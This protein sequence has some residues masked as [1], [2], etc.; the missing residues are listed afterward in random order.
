MRRRDAIAVEVTPPSSGITLAFDRFTTLQV[1]LDLTTPSMAAFEVGDDASWEAIAS[2]VQI[3]TLAA[4]FVNGRRKMTGKIRLHDIPVD[5]S[6]GVAIRFTVQTKMAEAAVAVADPSIVVKDVSLKSFILALYRPLGLTERD[7]IFDPATSRDLLTG[8]EGRWGKPPPN[9]EAMKEE[10]AVVNPPETIFAAADR[11]LRRFGLMHWDAPDGRIVVGRPD[12]EQIPI[13][14]FRMFRD[15]I[16][17]RANNVLRMGRSRDY[18]QVPTV[19]GIYGSGSKLGW[20]RA[21]VS[22]VVQDD[23]VLAAGLYHPVMIFADSIQ[24]EQMAKAVANREMS[25]R[26]RDKDTF[27]VQ[28]DGHSFWDGDESTAEFGIDTVAE[29]LADVI[30]GPQGAYLVHRVTFDLD[31]S[32]GGTTTLEMVKRGLWRLE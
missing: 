14:I 12:D 2:Y 19:L 20:Q 31:P 23:D 5:A 29:V 28:V 8:R 30:G 7:F 9:V 13:Y 18:S 26:R 27:S 25:A 22:S 1:V 21:K 15:A 10:Q 6:G 4:V 32:N 17:A 3:G 24:T 11:H 16:G